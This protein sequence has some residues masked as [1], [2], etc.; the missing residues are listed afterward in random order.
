MP[1][2]KDGDGETIPYDDDTIGPDD[3]VLRRINPDHHLAPT[4]HGYRLSSSAFS[5]SGA[6]VSKYGGMSCQLERLAPNALDGLP[7]GWGLVKV[8]AGIVRAKGYLVGLDPVPGDDAHTCV[9]GGPQGKPG[10][11]VPIK[12]GDYEW[13]LR[14]PKMQP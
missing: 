10:R 7:E 9:W 3:Y 11:K 2:D 8:R 12:D 6:N 13:V 5:E 1:L 14:P 4:D